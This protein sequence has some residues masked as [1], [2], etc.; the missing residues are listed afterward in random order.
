MKRLLAPFLLTLAPAL[1]VPSA[2]SAADHYDAYD[3]DFLKSDNERHHDI[4]DVFT[5]P[6]EDHKRLV[7]IM[8]THNR[9]NE[10]SMFDDKLAYTFR[11]RAG[12]IAER[13]NEYRFTCR[14]TDGDGAK[15]APQ[16]ASCAAYEI[17]TTGSTRRA[18]AV[19]IQG[20]KRS[21]TVAVGAVSTKSTPLK[22]FA[23]RRADAFF[24]DAAGLGEMLATRRLPVAFIKGPPTNVGVRNLTAFTDDLAIVLEVDFA[25]L[26]GETETVFRVAAETAYPKKDR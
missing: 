25:Q 6:S 5:F 21:T 4:V 12:K 19:V 24:G 7:M 16:R 18:S 13:G 1:L 17:V 26:F 11:V 23:G 14:F 22:V 2:S 8:N 20:K 9:A 15:E 3:G 10:L